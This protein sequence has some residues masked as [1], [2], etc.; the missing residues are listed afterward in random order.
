MKAFIV[1]SGAHGRVVLDI[2][3]AQG[4]CDSI[5]FIDDNES[6][7]QTQINGTTVAGGIE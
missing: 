7:W 4:E 5:Y 3:R 6:L 1:G 2:L